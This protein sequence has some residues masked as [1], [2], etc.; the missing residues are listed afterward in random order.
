MALPLSGP[1]PLTLG[2]VSSRKMLSLASAAAR[3]HFRLPTIQG[4]VRAFERGAFPDASGGV[5]AS[6]FQVDVHNA[7]GLLTFGAH[8]VNGTSP[9]AMNWKSGEPATNSAGLVVEY[10]TSGGNRLFPRAALSCLLLVLLTLVGIS[11]AQTQQPEQLATQASRRIVVTLTNGD[12]ISGELAEE[13]ADSV[14]IRQA[15]LGQVQ[16]PRSGISRAVVGNDASQTQT[17]SGT[18][19]QQSSLATSSPQLQPT[20]STATAGPLT[21]KLV[22]AKFKL[23]T[24]LLLSSQKQQ[25]YSGELDL[26]KTWHSSTKGWGHQRSLLLLSPSYDDKTSSKGANITRNY[27]AIFQ[28]LVFTPTDGLYVPVLINFYSNNSL[29]I[30]LQQVYGAGLGKAFGALELHAD[31]RFI[32]EHFLPPAA[33]SSP[34]PSRG[35]VGTGL[36]ER[37]DLSLASLMA[38]AKLTET[39]EFVPV[40]NISD[41]WQAHGIVE[42]SLPFTKQLSFVVS[43]FDNYVQNAPPTFR[44]NYFKTTIGF[45][46]SPAKK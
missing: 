24:G 10:K 22:V 33:P 45:Q 16:I 8:R 29:G 34:I 41:A 18:L 42:I 30:Y 15:V 25:S 36:S 6:E 39:L 19:L 3:A 46:Y 11:L 2:I 1:S 28:H 17:I 44:K 14:T 32:G 21:D 5:V 27:N 26:V 13:S 9:I 43:A 37:Y 23:S 20:P 7:A 4:L 40:F 12:I 38:G 31:L 35:L